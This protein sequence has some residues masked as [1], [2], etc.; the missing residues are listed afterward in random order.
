MKRDSPSPRI[1]PLTKA[2]A[3]GKLQPNAV[4]FEMFITKPV[5]FDSA[6]KQA[7]GDRNPQ[8]SP[9]KKLQQ[10][11]SDTTSNALSKSRIA[12]TNI[13]KASLGLW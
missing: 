13:S 2:A 8:T 9:R 1:N 11:K 5:S 6:M 7:G 4:A 12:Y 10:T 3:E